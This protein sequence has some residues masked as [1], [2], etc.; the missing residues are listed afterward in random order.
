MGIRVVSHNETIESLIKRLA[1]QSDGF[2]WLGPEALV[3]FTGPEVRYMLDKAN[4]Y[5]GRV[6]SISGGPTGLI[7]QWST[8]SNIKAATFKR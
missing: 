3:G 1:D 8:P 5:I 2:T 4:E 7:V 6:I